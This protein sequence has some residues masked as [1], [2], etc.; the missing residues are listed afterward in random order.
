VAIELPDRLDDMLQSWDCAFKNLETSDYVVGQVW[1]RKGADK[2]LIDQ[3]RDQM[4]CPATI[5][6]IRKLSARWPQA[7]RKLIE[8]KANGTAVIQVLKH[9]LTGMTAVQPAGGKTARAAAVCPHIESGNVYLPHPTLA[10]WVEAFIE[11]C[12]AFPR[13]RHDDQVDAMTQA[14]FR[15][16]CAPRIRIGTF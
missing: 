12:A 11:E 5:A 7:Q 4:D 6:A 1:A 15:I 10:P 8:D 3:V 14:L 2:F 9:E 13:G 16:A